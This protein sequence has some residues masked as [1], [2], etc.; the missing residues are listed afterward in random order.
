MFKPAALGST[1]ALESKLELL[2]VA[3]EK[4]WKPRDNQVKLPGSSSISKLSWDCL[5]ER[6]ATQPSSARNFLQ[7]H[8]CAPQNSMENMFLGCCMAP[9]SSLA[10]AANHRAVAHPAGSKP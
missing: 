2:V 7:Q 3:C 8:S 10:S 6:S 5:P 9:F 1:Q 4:F